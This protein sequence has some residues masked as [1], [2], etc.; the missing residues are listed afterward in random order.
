MN[1]RL[2]PKEVAA[3]DEYR[4]EMTRPQAVRRI[5]KERLE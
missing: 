2:H 4:G 1:V 3:L 5:V